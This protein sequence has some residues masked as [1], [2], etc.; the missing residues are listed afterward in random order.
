[1]LCAQHVVFASATTTRTLAWMTLLIVAT[2]FA[3]E[4][5][6]G[7]VGVLPLAAYFKRRYRDG[8][9]HE[10]ALRSAVLIA[11]AGSIA[12]AVYLLVRIM[13]Q[14]SL[15]GD[16]SG[17]YAFTAQPLVLFGNALRLLLGGFFIGDSAHARVWR[18][19]LTSQVGLIICAIYLAAVATGLVAYRSQSAEQR[20]GIRALDLAIV[21]LLLLGGLFPSL[22]LGK[23][24]EQYLPGLTPFAALVCAAGF[25]LL[26]SRWPA[27]QL[28]GKA[29]VVLVIAYFGWTAT[30][31]DNKQRMHA[32]LSAR[33]WGMVR[34][35]ASALPKCGGDQDALILSG[36]LRDLTQGVRSYSVFSATNAESLSAALYGLHDP[37]LAPR[38]IAESRS[39]HRWLLGKGADA[40]HCE[41]LSRSAGQCRIECLSPDAADRPRQSCRVD[42]GS[43]D[44]PE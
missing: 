23:V 1:V 14:A 13:L 36:N 32:E 3:K 39:P 26:A 40:S 38:I 31:I 41:V 44:P 2:L 28:G 25:C 33:H 9:R 11:S 30:V 17:R 7:L 5:T 27:V 37:S 8:T 21:T 29:Y 22:L 16:A 20:Q 42:D 43:C 6:V 24:S 4:T 34:E 12:L 15:H 10:Q 18:W 35:L 19:D